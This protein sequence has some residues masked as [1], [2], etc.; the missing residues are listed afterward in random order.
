MQVEC[1]ILKRFPFKSARS[2]TGFLL[3]F[4]FKPSFLKDGL[5]FVEQGKNAG[6]PRTPV[7]HLH[8]WA[9]FYSFEFI[10]FSSSKIFF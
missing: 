9:F 10:F 5:A 7:L 2:Q 8:L 6:L 4:I 3:L 1:R